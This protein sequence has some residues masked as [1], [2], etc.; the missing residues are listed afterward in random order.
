MS[1]RTPRIG[2][3][4]LFAA[5]GAAA[6]SV[7]ACSSTSAPPS[8]TSPSTTNT[9]AASPTSKPSTSPTTTSTSPGGEVHVSGLIAS[10]ANNSAQVT[11]KHGKATVNFT[12]S[13][14]VTETAPAALTDVTQGSCVSVRSDKG[15]HGND[16]VTAASV[17]VSPAVDGKCDAG[18]QGGSKKAPITGPVASVS[19]NTINVTTT[20]ASGNTAQTAVTVNDNTKY[21]KRN[22]ANAQAITQGKCLTAKGTKDG[23]GALQATTIDLR[24]ADNGK[25]PSH[26][27]D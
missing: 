15:S 14:K 7:A 11:Q 10:V 17:R 22:T 8:P 26:D 21:T 12:D 13:T 19:G 6:L 18:N 25:C 27:H 2:R 1:V 23:G 16:P 3:V 24:A 9:S 4:A 5:A 20:D